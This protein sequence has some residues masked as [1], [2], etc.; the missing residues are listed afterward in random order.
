ML[1]NYVDLTPMITSSDEVHFKFSTDD[2]SIAKGELYNEEDLSNIHYEYN[3]K[4]YS[5]I[6]QPLIPSSFH[7]ITYGI[8]YNLNDTLTSNKATLTIKICE[9]GC[10][11]EP[12]TT[13]FWSICLNENKFT[14]IV[15]E[16]LTK[17]VD[18][19]EGRYPY[20]NDRQCFYDCKD[21]KSNSKNYNHLCVETCP[22]NT[23]E[24][25]EDCIESSLLS[26]STSN[27]V[28]TSE[29]KEM[30]FDTMDTN[31]LSYLSIR[32]S[33]KGSDFI[34]QIYSTDNDIEDNNETSSIDISECEIILKRIYFLSSTSHLIISKFEL[35]KEK[36]TNYTNKITYRVMKK[37]MN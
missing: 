28:S 15:N 9:E 33:I 19:C 34:L 30:F 32:K 12:T 25:N 26:N 24:I 11:C 13:N 7:T 17:C 37:E 8:Y 21:Y 36:S 29:S 1:N 5:L 27:F 23:T 10:S 31:V 4:I 14:L 16:S 6:Y 22:M 20:Y 2:E 35:L 3:Y 18:K